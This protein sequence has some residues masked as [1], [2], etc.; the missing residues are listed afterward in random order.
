MV[1]HFDDD[2]TRFG[3]YFSAALLLVSLGAAPG[4]AAAT[5]EPLDFK[6]VYDLVH[7]HLAGTIDAELN[8]AAVE[9]LLTGLQ[10]GG[11]PVVFGQDLGRAGAAD[12]LPA[13][14]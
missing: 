5:N 9:G 13:A 7:A 4:E 12:D 3:F 2:M 1:T 11:C 14:R 6:E 10:E 8:R